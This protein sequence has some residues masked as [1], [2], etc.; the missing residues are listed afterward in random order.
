M[1]SAVLFLLTYA[2]LFKFD[3]L[4]SMAVFR[5]TPPD[6]TATSSSPADQPAAAQANKHM[7]PNVA[8]TPG[9]PKQ[10]NSGEYMVRCTSLLSA[11]DPEYFMLTSHG[12][13]V[14]GSGSPYEAQPRV[15]WKSKS[16]GFGDYV[17]NYE[18]GG[19][20]TIVKKGILP[21]IALT[22]VEEEEEPKSRLEGERC[23]YVQDTHGA[24]M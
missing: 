5:P 9:S 21:V 24:S 10:L 16:K 13:M 6:P 2:L 20:V 22:D 17:L 7:L 4:N 12:E 18:E 19:V 23:E 11:C 15:L 8:L 3:L 1:T 14:H